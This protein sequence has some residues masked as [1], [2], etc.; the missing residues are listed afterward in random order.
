MKITLPF[1]LARFLAI[2]LVAMPALSQTPPSGQSPPMNRVTALNS[3]K[4]K[5][6]YAIGL[7]VARSFQPISQDID[8][9]AL[10][11]AID[12]TFAGKPPA[13]SKEQAQATDSALRAAVAARSGQLP[14]GEGAA[15]APPP[16]SKENVGMMLGSFALGPSL[17][18]YHDN[19]DSTIF[20]QAL[21]DR[22]TNKPLLMDDQQATTVLQQ[23]MSTQQASAGAR[24]RQQ[25]QTFLASNV[26]K[27]GVKSTPSGLQYQILRPGNGPRP[28]PA[29]TVRVNYE[30]QLLDGKVFDSSYQ[31]GQAAEF[32][33]D[34][35][36][37]GW[38]EGLAL[39][40]VGA[41]YRFWIPSQLAYGA[42]GSPDGSIG[43]DATLRF[44]VELLSV[45]P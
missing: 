30:G 9:T 33:L 17:L 43:P 3:D 1:S 42:Q 21:R 12:N 25:G 23:F 29:S 38:T 35:V 36:I 34:Q 5:L 32:R 31:R 4:D 27:K 14:P 7:D 26:H 40:P 15:K 19:I 13:M 24:N 11:R 16:V 28:K 39:M 10:Q 20:I 45:V 41:K 44:D 6:S 8:L 37:P 18:K 2:F 22:Y